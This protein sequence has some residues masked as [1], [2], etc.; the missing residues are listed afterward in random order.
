MAHQAERVAGVRSWLYTPGTQPRRFDRAAAVGADGL[1]I[2]LEDA[3]PARDK[4]AARANAVA[5]LAVPAPGVLQAVRINP[6]ATRAG[7]RPAT[8]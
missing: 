8:P 4:A 6:P 5:Q 7:S 3:V 1:I 2:D